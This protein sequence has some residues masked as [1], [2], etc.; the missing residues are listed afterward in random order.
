MAKQ[1]QEV[2]ETLGLIAQAQAAYE[3]VMEEVRGYCQKARE[4]RK[5]AD[6]LGCSGSTNPHVATEISKQMEQ[7]EFYKHLADQKD[8]YPRLE[9][10]RRIDSMEREA[11]GLRDLIQYNDNVLTRQQIEL[12]EAE[13]EAV[14][15]VQRAKGRIQ[16]TKQLLVSQRA[17]LEK[18][19][20]KRIE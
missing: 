4:L 1:V 2:E 11:S 10:L 15:M 14:L 3:R 12:E 6:E 20:G 16:E 17:E 5:E 8:G 13:Q 7:A 19:E 18:L 9:I